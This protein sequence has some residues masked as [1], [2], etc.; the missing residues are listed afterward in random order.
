VLASD[1]DSAGREE[2]R[3]TI[4]R[5]GRVLC[6][7]GRSSDALG[8]LDGGDFGV[9]APAT[10]AQGAI[11]LV[12]RLAEAIETD[13]EVAGA[14][15]VTIRAGYCAVP[16]FA[17]SDCDAVQLLDCAATALHDLLQSPDGERIRGFDQVP[18]KT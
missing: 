4:E 14:G 13:P 7:T 15:R 18:L 10:G 9:I 8:R 16:D 11:A 2:A 17:A 12:R 6:Q 1:G 3:R 5:V